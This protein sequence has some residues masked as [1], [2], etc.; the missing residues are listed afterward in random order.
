MD[1]E[2]LQIT[3]P[4]HLVR[5]LRERVRTGEFADE[6]AAVASAVEHAEL[7][8]DWG[9]LPESPFQG[10]FEQ[11]LRHEVAPRLR[12]IQD[13]TANLH[14]I[15]EIRAHLLHRSAEATAHQ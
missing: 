15:D 13:G 11:Y 7:E 2:T 1:T 8:Q 14:T 5:R 10:S 6:D 3:L 9:S 12:A 4:A